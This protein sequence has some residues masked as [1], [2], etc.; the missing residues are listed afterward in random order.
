M[1][2][3][4]VELVR[5][6]PQPFVVQVGAN[7]HSP[8]PQVNEDPV[9]AAIRFGFR[10]L[11]IEPIPEMASR[12]EARYASTPR[13]RVINAAVC[14]NC[15]T[16][17]KRT[18]YTVDLTN[19]TGHWGTNFS[20]PR[21]ITLTG[22]RWVQELGSFR[23]AHVLEAAKQLGKNQ[24]QRCE[25]CSALLA[26]P[27]P[28]NCLRRVVFDN[29]VSTTVPCVCLK[30][31][32]REEKHADLL[33]VDTE[34][35]DFH[36]LQQYPFDTVETARVVYESAHLADEEVIAAAEKLRALGFA[37]VQGG[38]GKVSTAAWQHMN[39]TVPLEMS[40][41]KNPPPPPPRL[42]RFRRKSLAII[43][44]GA[45]ARRL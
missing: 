7:D 24:K 5:T 39:V 28:W 20:D 12:L 38:L 30:E 40:L 4:W 9:P 44:A 27:L 22:A 23:K 19:R 25:E 29:I 45:H 42:R 33:M 2:C 41:F 35:F 13:V 10:A 15:S 11:L 36:V 34:G 1:G 16:Q 14:G 6:Q 17:E 43:S 8:R 37:N 32:L 21:C 18:M 26:R 31:L 3:R